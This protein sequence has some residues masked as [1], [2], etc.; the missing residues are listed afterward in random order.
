MISSYDINW[1]IPENIGYFIST[2]QT[3]F[4]KGKYKSCKLL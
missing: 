2:N 4:S 3:G 1:H